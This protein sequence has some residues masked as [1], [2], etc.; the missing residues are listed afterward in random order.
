MKTT[1]S[2]TLICLLFGCKSISGQSAAAETPAQSKIYRLYY[3]IID[4]AEANKI[5]YWLDEGTAEVTGFFNKEFNSEFKVYIFSDRDSLD[6][7]WQKDW[8]MPGFKSQCWM[9]ASGIGHRL[10]ILSPRVW[11]SQACEHDTTDEEA[12]R[13]LILHE[14]VHV[15]HGQHNPSPTFENIDN[16]DWLLEGL[17]V[18]ASG[19]L[20]EDRYDRARRSI[21]NGEVPAQLADIWKGADRY[22]FAGSIVQFIDRKYGRDMLTQLL[23]LT[24]AAD[25]LE[26]LKTTEVE[27]LES[28]IN[29]F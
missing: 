3:D 26:V 24:K 22:G 8:N 29:S 11:N 28:W 12:T 16:I 13:K 17:A 2:F 27:L 5:A 19:Q 7:Q 10:D 25:V 1:F 14:L 9:V 20:D 21:Q 15:F 6:A 4:Q 18:Y 23:G